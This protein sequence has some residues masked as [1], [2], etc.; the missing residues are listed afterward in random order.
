MANPTIK[1][2]ILNLKPH[3]NEV[4]SLT[5]TMDLERGENTIV[6]TRYFKLYNNSRSWSIAGNRKVDDWNNVMSDVKALKAEINDCRKNM[7]ENGADKS[8]LHGLN[9][10]ID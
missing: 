7:A 2:E 3:S 4:L 9:F 1:D 8:C 5:S 6:I 10:Y